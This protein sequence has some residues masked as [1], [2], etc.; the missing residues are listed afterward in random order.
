MA[1][2]AVLGSAQAEEI[3]AIVKMTQNAGIGFV[4]VAVNAFWEKME[5][6]LKRNEDQWGRSDRSVAS[7]DGERTMLCACL[8]AC[9]ADS[10]PLSV[11]PRSNSSF[12]VPPLF[13]SFSP[14]P[15]HR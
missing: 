3:A 12:P 10:P 11:P 5:E 13:R 1:A 7:A 2:A 9:V 4:V 14:A 6:A 8:N 15:A